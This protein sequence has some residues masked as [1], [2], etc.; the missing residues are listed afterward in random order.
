MGFLITKS[1][2]PRLFWWK[3]GPKYVVNIPENAGQNENYIV[4]WSLAD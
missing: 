3:T 2:D 4:L 1:T